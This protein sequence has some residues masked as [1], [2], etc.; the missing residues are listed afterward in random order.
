[1]AE[2]EK[3]A[4]SIN[5]CTTESNQNKKMAVITVNILF[6][7]ELVIGFLDLR[8]ISTLR[9]PR[10]AINLHKRVRK[11]E[12]HGYQQRDLGKTREGN[13]QEDR[14]NRLRRSRWRLRDGGR[15][16]KQRRGGEE[17]KTENGALAPPSSPACSGEE[18][19]TVSWFEENEEGLLSDERIGLGWAG[20]GW[21]GPMFSYYIWVGLMI[22]ILDWALI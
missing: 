17:A 11:T 9:N 2:N 4:R 12:I 19:Q 22:N 20:L 1:M 21:V 8:D 18:F 16:Q 15:Q 5:K 13:T 7:G 14:S 6:E 10:E 3:Q